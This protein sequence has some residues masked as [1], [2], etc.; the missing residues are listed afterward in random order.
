MEV[1]KG[2]KIYPLLAGDHLFF[3]G[4]SWFFCP[5]NNTILPFGKWHY[6]SAIVI[7]VK[8]AD[9]ISKEYKYLKK[10]YSDTTK[11]IYYFIK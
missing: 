1:R 4:R 2:K 7:S 3:N 5:K 11:N 6:P 8:E 10:D 9:R